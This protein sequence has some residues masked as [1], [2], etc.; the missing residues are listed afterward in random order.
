MKSSQLITEGQNVSGV[1][2]K[3]EVHKNVRE[4]NCEFIV[5]FSRSTSEGQN[6]TVQG[7]HRPTASFVDV[8]FGE[9][10]LQTNG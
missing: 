3:L 10:D 8:K 1:D 4:P 5:Q 7:E 2:Q 6:N 9:F